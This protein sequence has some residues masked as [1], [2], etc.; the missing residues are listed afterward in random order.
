MISRRLSQS[1]AAAQLSSTTS[2][3][4]WLDSVPTRPGA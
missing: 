3:R 2:S 1:F 4:G